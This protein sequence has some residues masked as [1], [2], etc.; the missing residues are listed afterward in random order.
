MKLYADAGEMASRCLLSVV[1]I[2]GWHHVGMTSETVSERLGDSNQNGLLHGLEHEA[3]MRRAR[4]PLAASF[5]QFV[6][7]G[8]VRGEAEVVEALAT[9]KRNSMVENF[10]AGG[11]RQTSKAAAYAVGVCPRT[12]R[13]WI[14]QYRRE[15]LTGVRDCSSRAHH[16]QRRWPMNANSAT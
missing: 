14:D 6:P 12:V 15:G 11:E 1:M 2:A 16:H 5:Q 7:S 10:T 3:H 8:P 13:K 4:S 9:L